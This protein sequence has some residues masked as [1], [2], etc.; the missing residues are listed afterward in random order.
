MMW[1]E[2]PHNTKGNWVKFKVKT[3]S[4]GEEDVYAWPIAGLP[5]C[6]S[7]V[8]D[9][10]VDTLIHCGPAT[11]YNGTKLNDISISYLRSKMESKTFNLDKDVGSYLANMFDSA[12]AD[13]ELEAHYNSREEYSRLRARSQDFNDFLSSVLPRGLASNKDDPN[14]TMVSTSLPNDTCEDC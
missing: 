4:I 2:W 14:A 5:M 6:A 9:I 8:I 11:Q 12:K 13:S 3:Y 7:F 1:A 10:S